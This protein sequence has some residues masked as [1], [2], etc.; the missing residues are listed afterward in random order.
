MPY[1]PVLG[2]L[3]RFGK[4]VLGSVGWR[5]EWV[6]IKELMCADEALAEHVCRAYPEIPVS[7][8]PKGHWLR[9]GV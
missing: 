4:F 9:K 7:V 6:I 3:E 1:G 8:A 5:A 2:V